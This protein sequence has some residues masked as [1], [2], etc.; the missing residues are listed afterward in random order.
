MDVYRACQF[1]RGNNSPVG[2]RNVRVWRCKK[3]DSALSPSRVSARTQQYVLVEASY[4]CGG[5]AAC[6]TP[7]S[8]SRK[9]SKKWISL[10]SLLLARLVH[11]IGCVGRAVARVGDPAYEG[12]RSTLIFLVKGLV[13][14]SGWTVSYTLLRFEFLIGRGRL[15]A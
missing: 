7:D 11:G 3:K 6:G 5:P 13:V 15:G 1:L 10:H 14:C 8:S 2:L 9:V 4:K 12:A